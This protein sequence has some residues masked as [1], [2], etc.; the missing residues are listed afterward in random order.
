MWENP[1]ACIVVG[2]R[3]RM[4]NVM[5]DLGRGDLEIQWGCFLDSST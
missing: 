5:F 4:I 1:T 3:L 2:F